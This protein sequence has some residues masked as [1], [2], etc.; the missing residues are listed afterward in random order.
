MKK[1]DSRFTT[2]DSNLTLHDS[3][4]KSHDISI[5]VRNLSKKYRLFN[6][7]EERFKEALHPFKKKYHREFWALKDINFDVPK[8]ETVG[9]IGRNGSGKSTLLQIM[10]SVLKPTAGSVTVNGR[11][12]ALLELGAGFNPELTGRQNVILNGIVQGFSKGE[13]NAKIPKIQEFADIGEFFDQPVKIYSSGMF[14]RLAFASAINVDPDI[15]IVDEALAVGDAKFQHK[16]Y[17]KFL[18]FQKAGNTIVFVTH[19]MN[20]ITRHCDHAILLENGAMLENGKPKDAVNRYFE[21]LTMDNQSEKTGAAAEASESRAT[22]LSEYPVM[23]EL[24]IFLEDIP[25]T[26]NC[27]RRKSYN[28]NEYRFGDRRA[29]IIDYLVVCGNRIDPVLVK[30]IDMIDIYIKVVFHEPV[31]F[32][33]F[34][35]T[36]KTVDGLQIYGSNTWLDK[37]YIPP[38]DRGEMMIFNTS[39][40]IT[41]LGGDYFIS[42]GI[43]ERLN[44]E[45][46]PIDYR[47]DFIHLSVQQEMVDFKGIVEMESEDKIITRKQITSFTKDHCV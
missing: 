19:D 32:P 16:C 17:N 35:F 43:G 1:D 21:I 3:R 37:T 39:I 8:G 33:M 22:S 44:G 23:T 9:I 29:E 28:K 46:I 41:L 12:S 2:H 10:C 45:Y 20:A 7:P 27:I 4:F 40:K 36:I 11:I 26:D 24:E 13:M 31:Q 18:E 34:G 42:R 25:A 5:S 38:I 30:T 47:N 14:V 15:L 6:S